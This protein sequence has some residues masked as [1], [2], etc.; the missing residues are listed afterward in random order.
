VVADT[1][2]QLW[3]YDNNLIAEAWI[4]PLKYIDEMT[5]VSTRA[6]EVEDL[7]RPVIQAFMN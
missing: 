1:C 2:A 4:Q 3:K 5:F 7:K 6:V